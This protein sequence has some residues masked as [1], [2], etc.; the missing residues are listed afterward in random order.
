MAVYVVWADRMSAAGYS[1][2]QPGWSRAHAGVSRSAA[3]MAAAPSA[4]PPP[5][6]Q[7]VGCE[8]VGSSRGF[9]PC[10]YRSQGSDFK[11]ASLVVKSRQQPTPRSLSWCPCLALP[12]SG[13]HGYLGDLRPWHTR[14]S[15]HPA[16]NPES[17]LESHQQAHSIPSDPVT[18]G[19][20]VPGAWGAHSGEEAGAGG[21]KAG[22]IPA[23]ARLS[24]LASHCGPSLGRSALEVRRAF[25]PQITALGSST[26]PN[27]RGWR[28]K[29]C[30]LHLLALIWT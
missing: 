14:C 19:W 7:V 28:I 20:A 12:A 18:W 10:G 1:K 9:S 21:Q 16:L 22:E 24:L 11:A 8:L 6:W 29:N 5:S 25:P 13:V 2:S 23:C 30:S 15:F 26:S 27:T 17:R 4:T 3:E